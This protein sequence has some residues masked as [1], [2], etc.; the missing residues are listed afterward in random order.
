M[1]KIYI[2]LCFGLIS[3]SM[4]AQIAIGKNNV[5]SPSVSLEFGN[6]NRGLLLPWVTNLTSMGNVANGTMVF[7]GSDN[8][9]K[10]KYNS[11]WRSLSGNG[12]T[13]NPRST[14]DGKIIQNALTEKSEAKVSIGQPSVPEV[15]GILVLEESN[16]AMVLPKVA[17][18]HL[19]ILNP[20]PGLMVFDPIK[21]QLAVFNGQE[22]S[23]W[24]AAQ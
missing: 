1:N 21:R 14:V 10:V 23:Y 9:I 24:Q 19:N 12:T 15:S 6:E 7:D 3:I 20:T 5:S 2:I 11:G 18:P 13:I 8:R 16:K 22:W 17:A 4:Q